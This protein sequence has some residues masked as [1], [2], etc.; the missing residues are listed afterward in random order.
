MTDQPSRN[1]RIR[2]RVTELQQAGK[3]LPVAIRVAAREF[4]VTGEPVSPSVVRAALKRR[5]V[6]GRRHSAPEASSA[7]EV[8]AF[9]AGKPPQ[10]LRQAAACIRY[11]LRLLSRKEE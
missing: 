3:K 5:A 11:L 6:R 9:L 1:A 10:T 2:A 8:E 4:G 7:A